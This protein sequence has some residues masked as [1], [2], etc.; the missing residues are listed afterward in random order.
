MTHS[1]PDSCVVYTP[2]GLADAMASALAVSPEDRLLEPCMGGGALVEALVRKGAS[3]S[4]IRALELST[5]PTNTDGKA[6]VIRGVDF[7]SWSLET[8]ERFDKIVSNPPYIAL[9][10]LSE[11]LRR[12]ALEVED[13][14]ASKH[15]SL[16]CNYWFVFLCA[17]IRLLRPGG[18][19][20]F[21]LPA[22]WEYANYSKKFRDGISKHFSSF[23]VYRSLEPLFAGVQEGAVVILGTGYKRASTEPLRF[24]YATSKSLV[25]ALGR[26]DQQPLRSVPKVDSKK[27]SSLAPL[28]A[29]L[30]V[31]IGA[32]TGQ[33]NYFLFSDAERKARKLPKAACVPVVSK[34]RQIE[35]ALIGLS[36]WEAHRRAGERI[37]LFRPT[38]KV[39]QHPAVKRYLRLSEARG[40]CQRSRHKI[41][42][43]R[44]WS[45]TPL[46]RTADGFMSGM[47]SKGIWIAISQMPRLTATNTLYVIRFDKQASNTLKAGIAIALL[48]SV[49]QRGA[50]RIV[51]KYADGLSKIEPG[52]LRKLRIPV[53]KKRTGSVAEYRKIVELYL[54]GDREG[55]CRRADAWMAPEASALARANRKP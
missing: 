45:V 34:S 50:R 48:T 25:A 31:E 29:F 51:R 19:I 30:R 38:G 33:N 15:L 6:S 13:P 46:P 36:D 8:N 53:P 41:Q 3:H 47:S 42:S 22:A 28:D 18:S 23:K 55:A 43:R 49:A 12:A 5:A 16:G 2:R 35:T 9:N 27:S 1:F 26:I 14:V 20:C 24:E 7:V 44:P 37:W 39:R 17:S 52:D 54:A 4:K 10:R 40:G 21:L 32:V 11:R